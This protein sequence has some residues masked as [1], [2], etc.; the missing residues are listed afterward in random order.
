MKNCNHENADHMM[1]GDFC[2]EPDYAAID[3]VLVEQF[4]CLDCGAWLSLGPANDDDPRVQ[5]ELRGLEWSKL[6][7]FD[8]SRCTCDGCQ[9][10][11][12]ANVIANHK[13]QP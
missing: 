12:L 8:E 9:S 4:R 5:V 10:R 2:N 7:P 1:P 6:A 3:D 11:E 13:E